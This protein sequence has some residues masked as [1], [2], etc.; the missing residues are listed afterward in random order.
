M[1]SVEARYIHTNSLDKHALLR[2][3]ATIKDSGVKDGN[4]FVVK[5]RKTKRCK[6]W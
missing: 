2:G 3:K 6:S 4:G 5:I 1:Y